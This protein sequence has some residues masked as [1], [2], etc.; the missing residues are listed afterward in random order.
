MIEEKAKQYFDQFTDL[1]VL[2]L[3][4]P[5]LAYQEEVN[6]ISTSDFE[7]VKLE[8]NYFYIK[9]ML[10]TEWLL[11]KILLYCPLSAPKYN[12]EMLAFPI[13]D[14]LLANRELI[15]DDE[16]ELMRR[17]SLDGSKRALL[18]DFKK[19]LK[20]SSVQQ[21]VHSVLSNPAFDRKMLVRGL[22]SAFLKFKAPENG[23]LLVAKFLTLY[24]DEAEFAR[25]QKKIID[26]NLLDDLNELI[27]KVFIEKLSVLDM[28]AMELLLRKLKYN[29]LVQNLTLLKE[30]DPY[31]HLTIKNKQSI[32]LLNQLM[33]EA[34]RT[35]ALA[36]MI[37][38]AI[39]K[40][41]SSVHELK[42]IQ[43][44]G[45]TAD[46][47]Y[48]TSA[49]VW[50][51]IAD[52]VKVMDDNPAVVIERML[53]L[54]LQKGI[55]QIQQECIN[56]FSH[57]S[58]CIMALNRIPRYAYDR[59]EEYV[60]NYVQ[61][62]YKADFAYRKA[63]LIYRKMDL[64]EV[65]DSLNLEEYLALINRRYETHLDKLN[66]DWLECLNHFHFD[67]KQ[68]KFPIQYDFFDKE[69]SPYDQKIVVIISDALRYE[70]GAELLSE[71]HSDDKNTAELSYRVASIPSKTSVGMAQLLPGKLLTFNKGKI[72]LDGKSTE[73]LANRESI[74]KVYASDAR[75]VSF[76]EVN[77][78]S[79]DVNREIFKSK[80]VYIYHDTIDATGDDRRSE[81]KT[82]NAVEEAIDDLKR[83]VKKL[84][85]SYNVAKVLITADH[86][87]IYNDRAIE[88]KD[89]ENGINDDAFQKHN[90]YEITTNMVAASRGYCLPLSSTTK[91][92][93]QAFVS[94]TQA[95][96]R[97]KRQG[98][99]HQF[100]HGGGALQELIVP[101]IASTR[102]R[103]KVIRKVKPILMNRDRLKVVS[104]MCKVLILQEK[105]LSKQEKETKLRIGLYKGL[106]LVSNEVV[107]TLN[108]TADNASS[109]THE[110]LLQVTS[111]GSKE[112]ILKLKAFDEEDLLNPLIEELVNNN[113]LLATDF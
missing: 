23:S 17:Y 102:K 87:F 63:L 90:R 41:G 18:R 31:R 20:Y 35:D 43:I 13:M 19:E 103:D 6:Q 76:T 27:S 73:G 84:H 48:S 33:D 49:M 65:P 52:L 12:E 99:G 89:K 105:K 2:F 45:A 14:I 53:K 5:E 44:Y 113:T 36:A 72:Q 62:W 70:V 21:V 15:L 85:G 10:H 55:L 86:G 91:F 97:I 78:N 108:S 59:P 22:M 107:V 9:Y 100:V 57:S 58:E 1:R 64:S 24:L 110:L 54:K 60:Q 8:E 32:L 109:R 3:F 104:N 51:A 47:G 61:H 92:Q 40:G 112:S 38:D 96:N 93:D 34:G 71:L 83:F 95:V 94:I 98:V 80:L 56:F 25:F 77:G 106:E 69:V 74:L 4:D 88:E 26:N 39:S 111:Q 66:R 67:Y 81:S 82:F 79:T 75:A 30:E 50:K 11:K 29:L 7:V 101:V 28:E 42:L 46:F 16:G 37:H 68:L